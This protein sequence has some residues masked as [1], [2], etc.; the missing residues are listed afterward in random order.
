MASRGVLYL[1]IAALVLLF[2]RAVDPGRA[3]AL[4]AEGWTGWLLVVLAVGFA[5]YGLWRLAD[6]LLDLEHRGPHLS[7]RNERLGGI[8]SGLAHLFL[9]GQAIRFLWLGRHAGKAAGHHHVAEQ[10]V[11]LLAPVQ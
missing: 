1:V 9:A 3:L 10:H 11:D 4:L 5:S 8:G 7:A 2:D 6:G